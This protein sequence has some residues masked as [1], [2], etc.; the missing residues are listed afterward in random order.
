M[1]VAPGSRPRRQ[2]SREPVRTRETLPPSSDEQKTKAGVAAAASAWAAGR[3]QVPDALRPRPLPAR[4]ASERVCTHCHPHFQ[5]KNIYTFYAEFFFFFFCLLK[6][7]LQV[8]ASF[9][10][11]I[12]VVHKANNGSD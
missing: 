5:V 9:D 11:E 4:T 7:V 8:L 3:S 1:A 10:I 12:R 2:G 6:I